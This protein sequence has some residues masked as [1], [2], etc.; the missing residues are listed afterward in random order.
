MGAM[1]APTVVEVDLSGIPKLD[2]MIKLLEALH[3][4]RL[5]LLRVLLFLHWRRN[6]K[7]LLLNQTLLLELLLLAVLC[8]QW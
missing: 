2:E 6:F 5:L 3:S 8:N 1:R 4:Q 7:V